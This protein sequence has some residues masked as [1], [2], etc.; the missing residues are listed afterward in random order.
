MAENPRDFRAA[1]SKAMAD[2]LL[3]PAVRNTANILLSLRAGATA[4]YPGFEAL[5]DWGRTRKLEVSG[6]L[7]EY[8]R[9]FSKKVEASGG[10]VH[11]A[12]TGEDAAR[13]ISRIARECGAR[14]AVKSK[15]MTAEEVSLNEALADAGV[16]VTETDLG[17]F[18]IQLAGEKPSHILAPAIHKNRKQ[19]GELFRKALGAEPGLDV[20]GL[21]VVARKALRKRFL[22]AQLG[23]TGA[24]FAIAET[25]S[26]VLVTNEG[27][28]RM[29]TTLP[30]VHVAIVGIDKIIPS[31][32][33]LPGFL[34]L[35]TRSA[36]GQTISSYVT[37]ITGPRKPGEDEGPKELHVVLLDNGRSSLSRGPFREMLHC[38]HCGACL[39]QCPVYRTVGGHAYE[40]AYP[41][42][43]GGVISPLIWG[44]DRYPDLPDACTLCGRCPQACPVRIPLPDFYRK[45]RALRVRR[46]S[47]AA[48]AAEASATAVAYPSLYRGG[49]VFLRKLLGCSG[50][51][52][53]EIVFELPA[54][55]W[56]SC[57][58]LPK[59]QAGPSFRKWWQ[60][61]ERS[62]K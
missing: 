14:T 46:G 45:L 11:L 21:V 51:N 35:L 15:S 19:V 23:I 56:T 30:P 48:T 34:T 42:P 24:N 1:A 12:K 33:D 27:N 17:E 47:H 5:R 3:G 26:L 16:E 58:D 20:E 55:A 61:K 22:S 41:G 6:N 18:I 13:I 29:T 8:V 25:G 59:P 39:N 38:L 31:L 43:M 62:T 44:I 36:C 32:S 40:S 28:G 37:V 54:R 10:S 57:R 60:E 2:D 52:F 49:L 53:S 7:D 50:K 4:A 9:R